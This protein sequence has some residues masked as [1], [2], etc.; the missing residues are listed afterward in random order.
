MNLTT[1]T[2]ASGANSVTWVIHGKAGSGKTSL[3]G[4]LPDP[5]RLLYVNLEG[6]IIPQALRGTGSAMAAWDMHAGSAEDY[7]REVY[8]YL[9]GEG[10]E[11]YDWIAID[12]LSALAEDVLARA[13]ASNKDGRAA[14][15]DMADSVKALVRAYRALPLNVV[16]TTKAATS[17]QPEGPPLGCPQLPGKQLREWLPH[18]VDGIFALVVATKGRG[19]NKKTIR[20]LKTCAD[21]LHE[22]KDRSGMLDAFEAPDLSVMHNKVTR[23]MAPRKEA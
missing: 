18:E 1:T 5:A 20:Y 9:R 3:L 21:G 10:G 8:R 12:S 4:T 6:G 13:L 17:E 22:A 19:D 16:I 14:Y 2:D 23:G 7:M 15:G 11:L